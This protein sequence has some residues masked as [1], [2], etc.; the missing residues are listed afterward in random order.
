M[1]NL[2]YTFLIG[3]VVISCNKDEE[4]GSAPLALSQDIEATIEID[5]DQRF[6][7]LNNFMRG[8]K[9]S[10]NVSTSKTQGS[11]LQ[12]I[13]FTHT[14]DSYV[15]VRPGG[16]G[17]GCD[18]NIHADVTATYVELY[19]YDGTANT[20]VIAVGSDSRTFNIPAD[21][22]PLYAATFLETASS[23]FF[24]DFAS[25]IW[26]FREGAVPTLPTVVD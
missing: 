8:Q 13:W 20:V 23:L 17:E 18:N 1:K 25:S 22:R 6:D 9:P 7:N 19:T 24:A 14:S 11:T 4:Y 26:S 10:N 21:L 2:L 16:L 5:F 3:L 15:Y 12:L